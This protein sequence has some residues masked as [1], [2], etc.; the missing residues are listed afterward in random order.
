MMTK[1]IAF[2]KLL[3]ITPLFHFIDCFLIIRTSRNDIS[4]HSSRDILQQALV[5]SSC[6]YIVAPCAGDEQS[7][8]RASKFM[9]ESFWIPHEATTTTPTT[10]SLNFEWAVKDD[11][12]Q[13]YGETMGGKRA[14]DSRL[15]FATAQDDSSSIV[16]MVGIDVTLLCKEQKILYKRLD[17]E[18]K[19]KDAM[20]SLGP[21]QRRQYKG[22]S[23][24]SIV[25]DLFPLQQPAVVLS[26]LAVSPLHRRQGIALKL[27]KEVE[28][29][30]REEWGFDKLYLRVES[31]NDAARALYERQLD[32]RLEWVEKGAVALRADLT[33]GNFIECTSDTLTLAK[34]L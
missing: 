15:L 20:A 19:L 26:N 34:A 31:S 10:Q 9:L 2:L 17:A 29:V 5:E 8:S 3:L 7:I 28:R 33:S 21:K 14:F 18:N 27:C 25:Q 23:T 1:R 16:G 11:L 6:N 30:A 4:F 32:Y 22:S 12:M 13:R 24:Q